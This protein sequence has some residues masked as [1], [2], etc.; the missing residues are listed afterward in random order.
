VFRE[1]GLDESEV[2]LV[3]AEKVAKVKEVPL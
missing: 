2:E 1:L 3:L